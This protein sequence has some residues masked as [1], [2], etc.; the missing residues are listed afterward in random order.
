METSRSA[1]TERNFRFIARGTPEESTPA[2]LLDGVWVAASSNAL[3]KS[4]ECCAPLSDIRDAECSFHT[5]QQ[6]GHLLQIEDDDFCI[7]QRLSVSSSIVS[8]RVFRLEGEAESKLSECALKWLTG[9]CSLT[10]S[11][12]AARCKKFQGRTQTLRAA[13]ETPTAENFHLPERAKN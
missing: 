2:L 3:A 7:M 6:L 11:R 10:S 8:W 12:C 4:A 5:V 13:T 9:C 1:R